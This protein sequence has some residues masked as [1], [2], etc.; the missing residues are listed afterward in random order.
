[1]ERSGQSQI[2]VG[3]RQLDE[4][5][6]RVRPGF[7]VARGRETHLEDVEQQQSAREHLSNAGLRWRG[8]HCDHVD[9][10]EESRHR[11]KQNVEICNTFLIFFYFLFHFVLLPDWWKVPPA[12]EHS[13]WARSRVKLRMASIKVRALPMPSCILNPGVFGYIFSFFFN[14]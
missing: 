10:V 11:V 14:F 3:E 9:N 8:T 6:A 4:A 5:S 2:E 12:C 7:I 13:H 1:L